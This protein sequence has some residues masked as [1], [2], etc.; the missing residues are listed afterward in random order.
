MMSK[1]AA[2]FQASTET[3]A[4]PPSGR[5][6]L[7][8]VPPRLSPAISRTWPAAALATLIGGLHRR[9]S[10][11][12]KD[13]RQALS[14]E[15]QQWVASGHTGAKIKQTVRKRI[16]HSPGS[17]EPQYVFALIQ[18]VSTLTPSP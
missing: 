9:R 17:P 4:P 11:P 15:R 3:L 18:V 7:D 16:S 1:P 13:N 2:L 12:G 5:I 10:A 8:L 6:G 14:D